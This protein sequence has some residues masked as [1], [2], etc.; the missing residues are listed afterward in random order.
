MNRFDVVKL[1]ME[2]MHRVDN[3]QQMLSYLSKASGC[4]TYCVYQQL[5]TIEEVKRRVPEL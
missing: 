5:S 2:L 1:Y 4:V 3:I